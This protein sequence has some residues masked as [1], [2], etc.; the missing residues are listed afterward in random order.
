[1]IINADDFGIRDSVNLAV[2]ELYRQGAIT[3]A[4]ILAPAEFA[5]DAASM[6][7]ADNIPVAV[8]WTL[9]SEWDDCRWAPAGGAA[10]PSLMEHS[11]EF[12][13]KDGFLYHD[14]KLL[15][16]KAAAAD[17]GRELE[18][19]FLTLQRQ[20]CVPDH[21]DCHGTSLYGMNGRLF[22]ITAFRVC[23][24][25]GLP[26]R[27]PKR[28]DFLARQLGG[29]LPPFLMAAH[30]GIVAA[31]RLMGVALP[32]DFITDPRPVA[33]IKSRRDLADYYLEALRRAGPGTTEV[34]LHPSRPDAEMLARTAEW[35]K[36]YW[37]YEFLLSGELIDLAQK[38]GFVPCSWGAAFNNR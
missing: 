11:A 37:E 33:A 9:H 36:R 38:E 28:P 26:F 7:V 5:G 31:A 18:A 32:D 30:R 35:Q 20:N 3:S 27:F 34:F 29:S 24:R 4:S 15:A 23:R 12:P 25:H 17:V 16:K 14:Q 13:A 22:F 19:Q 10:V 2:Q 1:L 21:A 6:A 8:H